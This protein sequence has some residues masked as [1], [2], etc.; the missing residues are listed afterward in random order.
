M[1]TIHILTSGFINST[2]VAQYDWVYLLR[3][4]HF[5][6]L[7]LQL[8]KSHKSVMHNSRVVRYRDKKMQFN[9]NRFMTRLEESS[10]NFYIFLWACSNA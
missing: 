10:I 8:Q 3:R 6:I 9:M 5:P 2:T 4:H 1:E 7:R